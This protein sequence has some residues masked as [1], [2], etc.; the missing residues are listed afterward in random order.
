MRALS[1]LLSLRVSASLT[2]VAARVR[3][4]SPPPL[5]FA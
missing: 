3:G 5:L 1:R 4:I 2:I